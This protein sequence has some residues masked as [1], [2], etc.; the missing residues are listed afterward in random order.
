MLMVNINS[1]FSF[2]GASLSEPHTRELG[3]EISVRICLL[4]CLFVSVGLRARIVGQNVRV[5]MAEQLLPPS[6]QVTGSIPGNDMVFFFPRSSFCNVHTCASAVS[7]LC[8]YY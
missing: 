3:G 7:I 6:Q 4:A 8:M 2:I 5:S 1:P